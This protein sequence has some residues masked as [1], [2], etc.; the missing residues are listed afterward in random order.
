M[1]SNMLNQNLN[2]DIHPYLVKFDPL[3]HN[4][5]EEVIRCEIPV[6]F[7]LGDCNKFEKTFNKKFYEEKLIFKVVK[8]NF[9]NEKG[10]SKNPIPFFMFMIKSEL[11][12]QFS[13]DSPEIY[14][15]LQKVFEK[16][17]EFS[18]NKLS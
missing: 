10:K 17:K 5:S 12:Y 16:C 9:L 3:K 14:D 4:W 1:R 6:L 7:S 8:T 13:A 15:Y 11:V 2:K 18:R